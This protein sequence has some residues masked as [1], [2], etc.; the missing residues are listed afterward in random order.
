[1]RP[2][3]DLLRRDTL[4]AELM[5]AGKSSRRGIPSTPSSSVQREEAQ[6]SS[7]RRPLAF[8]QRSRKHSDK[9]G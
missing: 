1:M 6:E 4:Q 5:I 8:G 3:T 7:G 9:A 2:P